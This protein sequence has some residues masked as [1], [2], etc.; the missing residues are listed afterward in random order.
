[1][2]RCAICVVWLAI[3]VVSA[4]AQI[5]RVDGFGGV[6]VR[7]PFVAVDVLP[8]GGGTRVRAPFTSVRTGAYGYPPADLYPPAPIVE[9]RAVVSRPAGPVQA[10]PPT[11]TAIP[12]AP[13]VG[14]LSASASGSAEF[15]RL[16]AN[17]LVDSAGQ[18]HRSLRQRADGAIWLD[19]LAP[20]SISSAVQR[21]DQAALRSL[22][23]HYEGVVHNPQLASIQA[24]PGFAATH[25]L[26]RQFVRSEAGRAAGT[27]EAQPTP[28]TS[29]QSVERPARRKTPGQPTPVADPKPASPVKPADP[30]DEEPAE[31]G[32]TVS[33]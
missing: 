3:S 4:D 21:S 5:V 29:P 28:S 30:S 13:Q 26:L 31:R 20:E 19:Y 25:A 24:A 15:G 32:D 6:R 22:L 33:L 7:A 27:A 18:L 9:S 17:R 2:V 16:E 10:Y 11:A 8:F 23:N 12:S 14:S 1:M